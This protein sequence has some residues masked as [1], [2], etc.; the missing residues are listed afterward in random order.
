MPDR[1]D[2]NR[3]LDQPMRRRMY[4]QIARSPGIR[5]KELRAM[6]GSSASMLQWHVGK[7]MAAGLVRSEIVAGG[8]QFCVAP[9]TGGMERPWW[10]DEVSAGRGFP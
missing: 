7:L 4:E 5:A 8:R 9:G 10:R 3:V 1:V 2:L 6:V